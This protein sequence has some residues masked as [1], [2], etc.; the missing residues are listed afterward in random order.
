MKKISFSIIL[1]HILQ[2]MKIIYFFFKFRKINSEDSYINYSFADKF[3]LVYNLCFL[4]STML[5]L[6][7]AVSKNTKTKQIIK[8]VI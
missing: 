6:L 4:L 5:L 1:C 3:A 7:T 2:Y 8:T